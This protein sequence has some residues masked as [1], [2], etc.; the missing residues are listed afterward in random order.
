[1]TKKGPRFPSPELLQAAR[2][3]D[4]RIVH[5]THND[6]DAAGADAI[7]HMKYGK[8]FTIWCSVGKFPHALKAIAALPGN[9]DVLSIS[10]LGYCRDADISLKT[11]VKN[12]WNVEWRDHHKWT[13]EERAAAEAHSSLLHIDE[14]TCATGVVARDLMSGDVTAAEIARVVCDYDLWKHEDPRS[15]VLGQV[16][17][18]K[19]NQNQIRDLLA[20]GKFT[21]KFVETE[22]ARI[23]HE[24]EDCI[25]KSIRHTTIHAGHYKIAFAPLY[26]YPSETAHAIRD[27]MATDVEVIV[28]DKGRFSIRSVPPVSHLIARNFGG[29]GHPPAAGGSFPFTSWDR[30]RFKLTKSSKHFKELAAVAETIAADTPSQ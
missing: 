18:L 28:S 5:I 9:G 2:N 1:M 26:G 22:F 4:A 11:A 10:D 15:K 7:H 27:E 3:R 13:D 29:G 19:N 25:Q 20:E 8:V 12:K 6:L 21:N 17:S 14:T 30:F 24:R 23:N 16:C